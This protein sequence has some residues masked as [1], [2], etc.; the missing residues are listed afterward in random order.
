MTVFAE[1]SVV[2]LFLY[3]IPGGAVSHTAA[4]SG[5]HSTWESHSSQPH[6]HPLSWDIVGGLSGWKFCCGCGTGYSSADLG[7]CPKC[8]PRKECK[9]GCGKPAFY[10]LELGSFGYC[11]AECRDSELEGARREVARALKEFEVNSGRV[12]SQTT[13]AKESRPSINH[14]ALSQPSTR[15]SPQ[16]NDTPTTVGA[17]PEGPPTQQSPPPPP[18]Q[19]QVSFSVCNY[20]FPRDVV[21][22]MSLYD[23]GKLQTVKGTNGVSSLVTESASIACNAL[24]VE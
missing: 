22:A 19:G 13:A 17:T 24:C 8:C 3:I 23:R 1:F 7:A 5:G 10:S 20:K 11:G 2:T 18:P 6:H 16:S 21:H 15:S 12:I 4:L 9:S 14:T